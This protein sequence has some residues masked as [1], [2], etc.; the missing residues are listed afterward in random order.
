MSPTTCTA[1]SSKRICACPQWKSAHS[2]AAALSLAVIV[3]FAHNAPAQ[4]RDQVSENRQAATE[5]SNADGEAGKRS[6]SVSLTPLYEHVFDTDLRSSEGSV[7]INRAG[8]ALELSGRI[9]DGARWSFETFYEASWYNFNT[10]PD[11]IPSGANPFQEVH[12]L[13]FTPTLLYVI[14]RQWSVL[15]GGFVQFAGERDA[16]LGDSATY[17]GFGAVNYA[18]SDSLSFS[19]GLRVASQLESDASIIPFLGVTWAINDKLTLSTRGPRVELAAKA[20]DLLTARLFGAYESREYRLAE[21]SEIP[22][23]VIR[24]RR[25]RIGFGLDFKAWNAPACS[26]T[27]S[28]E[29]GIDVYQRFYFDDENGDRV[30]ADRTQPAPF[31][32]LRGEVVF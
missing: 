32:A 15:A 19:G 1:F 12:L 30:G 22:E 10:T 5:T 26:G 17:G 16:D 4:D 11:L 3:L 2:T 13:R 6:I 14:D 9:G 18:I 25:A 27:L 20:T 29:T 28:I 21:N 24:D 31:V 8:A 23:G 7:Q